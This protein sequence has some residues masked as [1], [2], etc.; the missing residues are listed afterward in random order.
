MMEQ[1]QYRKKGL[2]FQSKLC[3]KCIDTCS[4]RIFFT[5]NHKDD[6]FVTLDDMPYVMC[7]K[8]GEFG[9]FC[10]ENFNINAPLY[11]ILH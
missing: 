7:Q 3:H 1:I 5:K 6:M 10:I 9:I 11:T 8:V 4:K 2:I